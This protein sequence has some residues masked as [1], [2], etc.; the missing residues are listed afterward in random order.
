MVFWLLL[1]VLPRLIQSTVPHGLVT[2]LLPHHGLVL[3]SV[4]LHH[5]GLPFFAAS[6]LLHG[7]VLFAAAPHH[8]GLV[9]LCALLHYHGF[10]NIMV[11]LH[12]LGLLAL[13][14]VSA[15]MQP[16]PQDCFSASPRPRPHQCIT[17]L[18][19][20]SPPRRIRLCLHRCSALAL[21]SCLLRFWLPRS[22][23]APVRGVG[24]PCASSG[25]P[26]AA[27]HISSDDLVLEVLAAPSCSTPD[28]PV[29]GVSPPLVPG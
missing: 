16:H 18:P 15:S 13:H 28:D 19:W 1:L 6:L 21:A 29:R 26:G 25:L 9:L 8:L 17:A 4:S 2:A 10:V 23:V 12:L 7:L 3:V 14:C 27:A 22:P 20:R 5:H 24:A 11:Y